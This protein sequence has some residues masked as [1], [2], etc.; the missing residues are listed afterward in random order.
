MNVISSTP[1]PQAG[2]DFS[3]HT[4][5]LISTSTSSEEAA[6]SAHLVIEAIVEDIEVK[7]ELFARLDKVA[8]RWSMCKHER[9]H[10]YV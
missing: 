3:A 2:A 4:M 1:L 9:V 6:A 8:P 5:S 7:R 10:V